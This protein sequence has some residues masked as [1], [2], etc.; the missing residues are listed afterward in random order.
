MH[1]PGDRLKHALC[2]AHIAGMAGYPKVDASSWFA[3][4]APAKVPQAVIDKLVADVKKV[5]NDPAFQKKAEE[6]GAT[7]EFK[8]PAELAATV[9]RDYASWGDVVKAANIQP[10]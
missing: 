3:L 6:Q 1:Q 7:A 4:F 2:G 10:E 5:V 8:G 9:Q